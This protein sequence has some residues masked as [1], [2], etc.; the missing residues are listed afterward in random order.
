VGDRKASECRQK[1]RRVEG[2]ERLSPDRFRPCLKLRRFCRRKSSCN[3]TVF[4][5]LCVHPYF[6]VKIQIKQSC[7]Q[8][9]RECIDVLDGK[10]DGQRPGAQAQA[11]ALTSIGKWQKK[12]RLADS[13]SY[14]LFSY[15]SQV[16][17]KSII[18][19]APP[20]SFPS[21]FQVNEETTGNPLG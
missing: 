21:R 4:R 8:I 6:L 10:L 19:I 17:S 7:A 11:H 20:S 16:S 15:T 1:E 2:V 13:F 3:N 18:L 5:P 9:D 12:R 14:T